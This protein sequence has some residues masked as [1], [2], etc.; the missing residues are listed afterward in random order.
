M[1]YFH[2]SGTTAGSRRAVSFWRKKGFPIRKDQGPVV[3][4][5]V[6]AD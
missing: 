3:V 5:A 2:G 4:G 1:A 6:H